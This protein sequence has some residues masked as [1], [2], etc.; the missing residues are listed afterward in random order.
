MNKEC[1]FCEGRNVLSLIMFMLEKCIPV[2]DSDIY[3][4]PIADLFNDADD[5]HELWR[6]YC[7]PPPINESYYPE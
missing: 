3:D 5:A 1:P 4:D 2:I 6:C 7:D